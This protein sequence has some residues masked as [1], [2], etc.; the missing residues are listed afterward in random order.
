MSSYEQ[1]RVMKEMPHFG[2]HILATHPSF[3]WKPAGSALLRRMTALAD[4]KKLP[5]YAYGALGG[6]PVYEKLG[7]V[8]ADSKLWLPQTEG[9]AD[10][11]ELIMFNMRFIAVAFLALASLVAAAP[12]NTGDAIAQDPPAGCAQLPSGTVVC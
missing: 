12:P 4:G 11:F 1:V 6:V 8:A 3:Q 2:L 9:H 10:D 5:F 7:W